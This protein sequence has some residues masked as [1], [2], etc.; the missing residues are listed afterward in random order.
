MT[1]F[2]LLSAVVLVAL[3]PPAPAQPGPAGGLRIVDVQAADGKLTWIETQVVPVEEAITVE[4]EVNGMKVTVVKKVTVYKTVSV[5]RVAD[6]KTAKVTDGTGKAVGA[7]KLAERLKEAPAVLLTAPLSDK[8]HK[9]F[10]DD[11]LF[12]EPNPAPP[13]KDPKKD[14]K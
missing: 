4:E 6:L 11:T 2:A 13:P 7:D 1:R 10:K 5:T 9:L 12:I 8:H 3:A 14:K